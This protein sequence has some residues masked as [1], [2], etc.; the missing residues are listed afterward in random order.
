MR[1]ASILVRCGHLLVERNQRYQKYRTVDQKHHSTH[2]VVH[3]S[4]DHHGAGI[5]NSSA[6]TQHGTSIHAKNSE[7]DRT[8]KPIDFS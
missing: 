2:E 3:Q 8:E 6:K 5:G 7:K 1:Y 4:S